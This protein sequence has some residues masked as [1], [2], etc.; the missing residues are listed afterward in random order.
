MERRGP[1]SKVRTKQ[2]GKAAIDVSLATP[3]KIQTLRRKLY[4]KAKRE[5][6]YCFYALYEYP[7]L[8]WS[9]DLRAAGCWP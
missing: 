5:P 1:G 9:T 4:L 6:A 3:E 2:Q 7:L 8:R